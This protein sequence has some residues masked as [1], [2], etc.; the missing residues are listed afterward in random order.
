MLCVRAPA[1]E[2][3]LVFLCERTGN[4]KS[5]Y[6]R[7]ALQ[8]LF[9]EMDKFLDLETV[10]FSTQPPLDFSPVHTPCQL[11]MHKSNREK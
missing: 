7:L 5:Y 4:T 6:V 1:F 10:E 9:D 11:M 2:E 8:I 3:R